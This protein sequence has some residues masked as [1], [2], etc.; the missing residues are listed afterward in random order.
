MGRSLLLIAAI[1]ATAVTPA[2]A[3]G[4]IDP[5]YVKPYYVVDR[6]PLYSGPGIV[7]APTLKPFNWPPA[8]Y[9]Y[10]DHDYPNYPSIEVY[11]RGRLK[12]R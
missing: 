12:R 11:A 10:V 1:A 9:P 2:A 3:G 4:C 8:D 6:G 7:T 5:C